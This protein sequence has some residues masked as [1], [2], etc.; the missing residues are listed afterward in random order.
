[1]SCCLLFTQFRWYKGGLPVSLPFYFWGWLSVLVD[2]VP[3]Y[4]S[5]LCLIWFCSLQVFSFAL[6][7]LCTDCLRLLVLSTS[8][9]GGGG[10][11][12]TFSD[13]LSLSLCLLSIFFS[14]VKTYTSHC[15]LGLY[16]GRS[17]F[18]VNALSR[19]YSILHI[20]PTH[21]PRIELH[22]FWV[23][24]SLHKGLSS[25]SVKVCRAAILTTLSQMGR[26]SS[27]SVASFFYDV[28]RALSLKEARSPRRSP[29]WIFF[30]VFDALRRTPFEPL[31]NISMNLDLQDLL[32]A[33]YCFG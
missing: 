2:I 19:P 3:S 13:S 8:K 24:L 27:F 5:S 16:M 26:H 7:L 9:K 14:S 20:I 28:P 17:I 15:R 12:V 31:S 25:S 21:P 6:P 1:M 18:W 10:G 33:H 23:F 29:A 22:I 11:G 4:S 32:S 30:I